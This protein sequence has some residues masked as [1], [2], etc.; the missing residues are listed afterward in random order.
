[1]A[2]PRRPEFR[3]RIAEFRRRAGLTQEQVAEQVGISGEM[4]RRHERG[5][6]LPIPLYRERY[7]RALKASEDELWQR[8][9]SST[10]TE[11][12]LP[13]EKLSPIDTFSLAPSAAA[14]IV[15]E[16]ADD[17]YLQ[18]IDSHIR[19]ILALDNRFGGADLVRLAKRFFSSLHNQLGAGNFD[20]KIERDL[21]SAVGELAEVIGWIA[22]DSEEHDLVRRMNQE[23]LYFTRLSGDKKI[24]LLTLQNSSM[25]AAVQGR[26]KEALSLARLVLEGD[27]ELSARLRAL[28][29]TRKARA[30]A[31]CGDESALKMFPEIQS[32]F[33]EGVSDRDPPWAWWVDER[34][35]A[36]H[37]AMAN[38][39]LGRI[40]HAIEEFEHSV[41]ATQAT[42]PRSQY[43]HRAYLLQQQ[44]EARSWSTAEKTI[45]E[46]IPLATQ[47]AS[48]R[49]V[50][51]IRKSLACLATAENGNIPSVVHEQAVL[52]ASTLDE[53]T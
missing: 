1:M 48:T 26:P 2:R 44:I 14:I 37:E 47:V 50:V 4:V 20:A 11:R 24:E 32:L 39:D 10:S 9:N 46:L 27:Y 36:W 52:L 53:A 40:A 29:L 41:A 3:S 30:L 25:H 8:G 5:S 15:P 42:E 38:K 21:Q 51:I 17:D 49:T 28:F 43:L 7:C 16:Y 19:E 31:Q 23:S 18:A 45:R 12:A 34:E 35:L 33:L 13:V 22:Y 6:S